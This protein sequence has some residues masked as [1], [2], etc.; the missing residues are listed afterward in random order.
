MKKQETTL[1]DIGIKN[2]FS[3]SFM[4]SATKRWKAC[5]PSGNRPQDEV[6]AQGDSAAKRRN[7][8]IPFE[9]DL[10]SEEAGG[11]VEKVRTVLIIEDAVF[12]HG[13]LLSTL[14]PYFEQVY[15]LTLRPPPDPKG[16]PVDVIVAASAVPWEQ[17]PGFIPELQRQYERA[18]ILVMTDKLT[19]QVADRCLKQGALG[20]I[21]RHEPIQELLQ[22]IEKVGRY[23]FYL[24]RAVALQLLLYYT[25][26]DAWTH[27]Q[28]GI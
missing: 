19:F 12:S 2:A 27:G 21:S 18:R 3:I 25:Q 11:A 16:A 4:V 28:A 13:A 22:A 23:E 7:N 26:I 15:D 6:S 5:H 14:E 17:R 1:V 10:A 9:P 8:I 24:P 20:C